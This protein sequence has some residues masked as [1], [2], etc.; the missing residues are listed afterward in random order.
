M[1]SGVDAKQLGAGVRGKRD[2]E[3]EHEAERDDQRGR[4]ED[5]SGSLLQKSR[6]DRMGDT[7]GV[8][9]SWRFA[10]YPVLSV[11]ELSSR[12]AT[13]DAAATRK[14]SPSHTV[15]RSG[16]PV[17]KRLAEPRVRPACLGGP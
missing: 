11:H 14:G 2:A 8:N 3:L 9:T 6:L 1:R 12:T 17:A 5:D 7:D 15:A 13:R 10:Y 4:S 16:D